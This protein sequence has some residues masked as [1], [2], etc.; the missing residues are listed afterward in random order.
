MGP[1]VVMAD[2]LGEPT[3][4]GVAVR[5][6]DLSHPG[7]PRGPGSGP[8]PPPQPDRRPRHDPV[9]LGRLRRPL[10]EAGACPR[11]P[12]RAPTGSRTRPTPT[13]AASS[14]WSRAVRWTRCPEPPCAL[15]PGAVSCATD[16][17]PRGHAEELG[18][19]V[20]E[21]PVGRSAGSGRDRVPRGSAVVVEVAHGGCAG[22][23]QEVGDQPAVAAPPEG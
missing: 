12:L 20:D 3:A 13:P 6:D 15:R 14:S 4:A 17:V 23:G 11:R 7:R 21:N 18:P 10:A 5:P 22:E 9:R 19:V 1:A 16:T 8:P 2:P